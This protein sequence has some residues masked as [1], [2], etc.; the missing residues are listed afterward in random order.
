MAKPNRIDAA[1]LAHFGE[2]IQPPI[3]VLASDQDRALQDAVTRRR[4]LVEM[5]SAEKNRR[6]SL[7]AKMRQN[8][9]RHIE[10]LEEQIQ[11]LDEEIEQLSQAQA[12]WQSRITLLKTVP[13]VGSVI[14]TTLI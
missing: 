10:W 5:L 11:E 12:E 4:Q 9:E 2:A 7:R 1:V 6:A 8:I 14:A 3:T 13:G